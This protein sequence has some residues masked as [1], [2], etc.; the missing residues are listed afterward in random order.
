MNFSTDVTSNI[1]RA[2]SNDCQNYIC[3]I[4]R[5]DLNKPQRGEVSFVQFGMTNKTA[6]TICK[7]IG[8]I[9]T[10]LLTKLFLLVSL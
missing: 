3:T 4:A 7:Y 2:S 10:R 9:G 5:G 1:V 8:Y 6:Q